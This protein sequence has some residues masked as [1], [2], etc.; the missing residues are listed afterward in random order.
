MSNIEHVQF[1]I[2]NP[3]TFNSLLVYELGILKQI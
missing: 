2:K 3:K 1:I